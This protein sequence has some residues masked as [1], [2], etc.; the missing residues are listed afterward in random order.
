MEDDVSVS[1][2]FDFASSLLHATSLFTRL[3]SL[4]L[5]FYIQVFLCSPSMNMSSFYF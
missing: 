3:S 2:Y 4:S 5:S 1:H